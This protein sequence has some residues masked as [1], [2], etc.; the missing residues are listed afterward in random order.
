MAHSPAPRALSGTQDNPFGVPRQSR[1]VRS[2]TPYLLNRVQVGPVPVT[3][4]DGMPLAGAVV[5]P[6]TSY[7]VAG[8]RLS[9]TSSVLGMNHPQ[10]L[11][12]A[13]AEALVL[14]GARVSGVVT[15]RP[16]RKGTG[17]ASKTN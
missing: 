16:P 8:T 5:K 15:R 6:P 3:R 2:R 4:F 11:L 13:K 14:H 10:A 1:A 9:V 12:R 17:G 7:C